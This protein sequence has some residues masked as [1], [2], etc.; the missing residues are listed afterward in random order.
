M[1]RPEI[2]DNWPD[3]WKMSYEYDKLELWGEK[4]C[5]GY[6]YAY[7][8]RA[9]RTIELVRSKLSPGSRL[10]DIAAAQGNFSIRLAELG[11]DVTWNDL[12]EELVD[13]V[14]LKKGEV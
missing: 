3:S 2:N 13:Y 14:K 11:Y 9:N 1:L 5:L 12:R 8:N 4:S 10:L 6:S 7:E